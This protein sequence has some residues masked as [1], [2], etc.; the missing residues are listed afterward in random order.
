MLLELNDSELREL[1]LGVDTLIDEGGITP[2][3]CK[4]A[5][6]LLTHIV[7]GLEQTDNHSA[8]RRAYAD[9]NTYLKY[10]D[11]LEKELD[12]EYAFYRIEA[13]QP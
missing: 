13:N 8:I 7:Q 5:I 11:D 9:L 1:F 3:N 4:L 10:Q 6:K 2:A 12:D